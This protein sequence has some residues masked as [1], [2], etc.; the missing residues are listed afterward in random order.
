MIWL[1]SKR[2]QYAK[3]MKMPKKE[4]NNYM[5]DWV[6]NYEIEDFINQFSKDF[7]SKN[8][9]FFRQVS[10]DHPDMMDQIKN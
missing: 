9:F 6:A 1:Q 8:V 3:K 10:Y 5:R 4:E 7:K 2:R